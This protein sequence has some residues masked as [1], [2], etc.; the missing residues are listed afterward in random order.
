MHCSASLLKL[1]GVSLLRIARTYTHTHTNTHIRKKIRTLKEIHAYTDIIVRELSSTCAS[2]RESVW[3][4]VW[5]RDRKCECVCVCMREC[6]CL[7]VRGSCLCVRVYARL[8]KEENSQHTGSWLALH[9]ITLRK[10]A[11]F[12]LGGPVQGASLSP[13]NGVELLK[14]DAKLI[15][16]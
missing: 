8:L 11:L 15:G 1:V 13:S 9:M 16:W 6:A 4:R 5:V 2:E 10:I 12:S 7:C 14:M 3:E